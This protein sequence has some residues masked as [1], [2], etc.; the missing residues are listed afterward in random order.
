MSVVTLNNENKL[1]DSI[2]KKIPDL[3]FMILIDKGGSLLSYFI[4]EKCS[5]ECDL[6]KLKD[7]A[8]L[9]SIRFS[10]GGFD[11]LAGGLDLT[12][13]LFKEKLVMTREIFQDN[14][15]VIA[16]ARNIDN[17]VDRTKAVLDITDFG[18][19]LDLKDKSETEI[20]KVSSETTDFQKT[21]NRLQHKVYTIVSSP[22]NS[23]SFYPASKAYLNLKL[24]KTYSNVNFETEKND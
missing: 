20:V 6:S 4:S 2:E 18:I 8:K 10:I 17:L 16:M 14:L 1:V 15:M 5:G 11:K 24:G 22:V 13:N 7:I 21:T 19:G 9:V 3:Y 23:G 12:I